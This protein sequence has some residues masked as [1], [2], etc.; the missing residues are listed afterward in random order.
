[1]KKIVL[2]GV[3]STYFTKGIVESLVRKGGQWEIRL[4]DIDENCLD[5]AM[6]LTKRIIDYYGS[7]VSV[8]GSTERKDLLEGADAVVTTIGV[9]GRKA[10]AKDVYMFHECGIFQS[11][12]DTFGPGGVS[13]ALRTIPVLVEIAKDIEKLCKDAILFNFTNPMG[14][15]I[16]AIYKKTSVK[17]AGLCYGVTWY[18]HMLSDFIEVPFE[19]T[20]TKA[21]GVNHFTW[22]TDFIYQGKN[23]WPLVYD[24]YKKKQM[25]K[26]VVNQPY[27]WELF[28]AFEAFPCVGDG[29]ICE[30]IPGFQKKNA[31]YGKTFGFDGGHDIEKYLKHWDIVFEEMKLQA[32]G[33][34]E[35][36]IIP[37]ND[38]GLTF[39]DEDLF[40]DVLNSALGEDNIERT[41]NLPN[42]GQAP[43][44]I[45]GAVIEQTTRINGSGFHPLAYINIP[46]GIKATM[47]RILGAQELTVDAALKGDRKLLVETFMVDLTAVHKADAEKLA[48]LIIKEHK[49][50]LPHFK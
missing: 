47:N 31:Y 29:H 48:D 22:I 12:G 7:D 45:N 25:D 34:K 36:E 19:E 17:T 40:I 5:I 1:M 24:I 3:G 2:L 46:S 49:E 4:C 20:W 37:E 32:N 11:T 35:L 28:E 50:Y 41:V 18:Q 14:P 8:K 6:K 10:W 16:N 27:T 39:R 9:G 43:G 26:R 15:S 42:F 30:F 13:R 38:A 23:A 21:V 44:I 33:E